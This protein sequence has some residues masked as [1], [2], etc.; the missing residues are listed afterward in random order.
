MCVI[1][2]E[3]NNFPCKSSCFINITAYI[4]TFVGWGNECGLFS[5][6]ETVFFF[7]WYQPVWY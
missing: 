3:L 4:M 7:Y 1:Q 6:T 5:V 2:D